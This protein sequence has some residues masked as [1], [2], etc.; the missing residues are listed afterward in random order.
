MVKVN[1]NVPFKIYGLNLI[2]IWIFSYLLF[3]AKFHGY[4]SIYW[5]KV[6]LT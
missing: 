5:F 4:N 2:I 6:I 3:K 1:A